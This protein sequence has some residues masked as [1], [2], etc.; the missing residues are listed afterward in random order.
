MQSRPL[1]SRGIG[2]GYEM[3]LFPENSAGASPYQGFKQKRPL[4]CTLSHNVKADT[5]NYQYL[6]E[7][8]LRQFLL[9]SYKEPR[10]RK[11]AYIW[12]PIYAILVG[13]TSVHVW[14]VA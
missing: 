6:L 2:V 5:S 12:A 7:V 9:E 13:N 4:F 14:R 10:I 8:Y 3:L 11:L 1:I